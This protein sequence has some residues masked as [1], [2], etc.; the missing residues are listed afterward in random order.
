M[1]FVTFEGVEGAGKSTQLAL[2]AD[3]LRQMGRRVVETKEPG[4]TEIGKKIRAILLDVAHENLDPVAEWLLDAA[5]RRHDVRGVL[6]QETGPDRFVRCD[7]YSD[8]TEAYQQVGRGLNAELV[9][10][11]DALARDGLVPDLTLVYDIAS[12]EGLERVRSRH[13]SLDR[14]EAADLE[15]HRRAR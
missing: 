11:I 2:A 5:D 14:F 8:T 7:R 12:E 3:R 4:G 1:P 15:F 6:K 9:R 10:K 13:G